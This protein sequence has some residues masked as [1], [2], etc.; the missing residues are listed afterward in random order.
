MVRAGTAA[1]TAADRAGRSCEPP[2]TAPST[3]HFITLPER[4]QGQSSLDRDSPI[5]WVH[6]GVGRHDSGKQHVAESTS[7]CTVLSPRNAAGKHEATCLARQITLQSSA[8]PCRG[9]L[10]WERED[11]SSQQRISS[12]TNSTTTSCCASS[13][14]VSELQTQKIK[15]QV[16]RAAGR[17][18]V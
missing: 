11:V 13:V 12:H 4:T 9:A 16:A 6:R 10:G 5:S 15:I 3:P 1:F 7:L 14:S 17:E 8:R 2:S 18:E